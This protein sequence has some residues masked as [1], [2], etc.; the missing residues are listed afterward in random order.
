MKLNEWVCVVLL[1]HIKISYK[2]SMAL[3]EPYYSNGRLKTRDYVN[4]QI[5][6]E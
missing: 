4:I 2:R 6:H 1:M 3:M 5:R